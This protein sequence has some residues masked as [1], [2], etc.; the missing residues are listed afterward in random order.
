MTIMDNSLVMLQY[1]TIEILDH[2]Q[3]K[4]TPRQFSSHIALILDIENYVDTNQ[5]IFSKK[6]SDL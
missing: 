2:V 1:N 5:S 4:Q 3:S 6:P